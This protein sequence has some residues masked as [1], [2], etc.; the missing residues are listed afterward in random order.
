MRPEELKYQ[1]AEQYRFEEIRL[2]QSHM[3]ANPVNDGSGESNQMGGNS[4]RRRNSDASNNS[5]D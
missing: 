5:A 2:L 4:R 1:G 3:T